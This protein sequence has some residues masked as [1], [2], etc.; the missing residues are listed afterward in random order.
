M[1]QWHSITATT[2]YYYNEC[3]PRTT[4]AFHV[5][6]LSCIAVLALL[7]LGL[8][9]GEGWS[10]ATLATTMQWHIMTLFHLN[11]SQDVERECLNQLNV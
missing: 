4:I 1:F 8:Y 6:F 7:H 5:F 9:L 2:K 3:C 10:S 11:I